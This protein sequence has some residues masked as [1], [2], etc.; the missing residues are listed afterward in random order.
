MVLPVMAGHPRL[1]TKA[2]AAHAAPGEREEV[3]PEVHLWHGAGDPLVPAEHALQLAA[4][5]PNCRVF[6][7]PEEGHHF[8]R[9]NLEQILGSL[10]ASDAMTATA[11]WVSGLGERKSP[12]DRRG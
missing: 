11:E 6:V 5:L 12:T 10:V 9:A 1:L 8:F 3:Q 7:D 2:I 4:T